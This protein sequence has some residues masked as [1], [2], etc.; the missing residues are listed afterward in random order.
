MTIAMKLLESKGERG[1]AREKETT[2][3]ESNKG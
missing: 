1:M 2:L 3:W